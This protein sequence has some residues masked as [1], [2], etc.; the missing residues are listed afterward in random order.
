M[1]GVEGRDVLDRLVEAEA[2]AHRHVAD[3]GGGAFGLGR[4]AERMIVGADALDRAHRPRAE[5]RAGAVGDAEI[6]RDADERHVEPGEIGQIGRVGPIGQIEQGRDAGIGHRPA[7]G[8]RRTPGRAACGIARAPPRFPWRPRIW[9][10]TRRAWL[11]RTWW[12][13]PRCRVRLLCRAARIWLDRRCENC[14]A[15]K[16]VCLAH[17]R[18]RLLTSSDPWR[19]VI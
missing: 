7:I 12:G 6:H 13:D 10:A 18:G 2:R 5:A 19:L 14:L 9:R 4:D 17:D 8:A 15:E 16:A 1:R 3:I 11:C